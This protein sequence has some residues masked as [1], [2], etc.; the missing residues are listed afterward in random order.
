MLCFPKAAVGTS[1]LFSL[2]AESV[3]AAANYFHTFLIL[4]LA[5]L[6]QSR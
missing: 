1:L 5:V 6:R 2:L 3:L 4:R